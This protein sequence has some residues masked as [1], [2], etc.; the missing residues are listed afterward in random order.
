[1]SFVRAFRCQ[2]FSESIQWFPVAC[3]PNVWFPGIRVRAIRIPR[4]RSYRVMVILRIDPF[5]TTIF[6][7]LL[8]Y[9]IFWH[10]L[11]SWTWRPG[12]FRWFTTLDAPFLLV[13]ENFSG[14]LC[15]FSGLRCL[16][17][18]L[19]R[20]PCSSPCLVSFIGP[21]DRTHT[22]GFLLQPFVRIFRQNIYQSG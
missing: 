13:I 12:L 22:H 3:P 4:H 15:L 16:F 17:G 21:I 19:L 10:T 8:R 18:C 14:L 11:W 6:V 7:S 2:F 9:P 1:M 5:R 20:L